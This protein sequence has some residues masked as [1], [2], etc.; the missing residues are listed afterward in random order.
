LAFSRQLKIEITLFNQPVDLASVA[1]ALVDSA[2]CSDLFLKSKSISLQAAVDLPQL[3]IFSVG[4]T[5]ELISIAFGGLLQLN[6]E[7]FSLLLQPTVFFNLFLKL[8]TQL[9]NQPFFIHSI[10]LSS[11]VL[12]LF[13]Y[14]PVQFHKSN[15][16]LTL[17]LPLNL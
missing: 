12:N 17:M 10:L 5:Q 9:F 7:L 13:S 14:R 1:L 16:Q 3:N 2:D 6:V 11:A 15:S 4:F 8:Q